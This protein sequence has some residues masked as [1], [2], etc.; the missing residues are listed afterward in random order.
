MTG[1]STAPSV[2]W[3]PK[4]HDPELERVHAA[5][6]A[7][8]Y[9]RY[10]GPE[11][12]R[13][14]HP[15]LVGNSY[16]QMRW[17]GHA[18]LD[19][20][21]ERDPRRQVPHARRAIERARTKAGLF[22]DLQQWPTPEERVAHFRE[23]A[24]RGRLRARSER[25]HE[26]VR[27]RA[28]IRELP[29]D[30][31]R[32]VILAWNARRLP[33]EYLLSFIDRFLR[34]EITPV[35]EL[36]LPADL[37][38][39]GCMS[40]RDPSERRMPVTRRYIGEALRLAGGE[41]LLGRGLSVVILTAELGLLRPWESER[42]GR[43]LGAVGPV[44]TP[45]RAAELAAD[46]AHPASFLHAVIVGPGGEERPPYRR[47]LVGGSALHQQV[48]EAWEHAGV[49]RG[50]EVVFLP[51]CDTAQRDVLAGMYGVVPSPTARRGPIQLPLL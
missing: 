18:H 7:G 5:A 35:P 3:F 4:A 2:V 37:L 43:I 25:A 15:P 34:G 46:A 6:A 10:A 21:D 14:R 32:A 38:I 12:P 45:A 9:R 11:R 1:D 47:V 8:E 28:R 16:V 29:Q 26:L 36:V 39:L 19:R 42:D 49:F 20:K 13:E 27:A 44:L 22:A 50:A 48:V 33:G 24:E 30:V 40:A 23:T 41:A 31:R 17:P 51:P